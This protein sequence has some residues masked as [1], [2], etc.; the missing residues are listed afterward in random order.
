MTKKIT[1]IVSTH[2]RPAYLK[3]VLAGYLH[4]T[5]LPGELVVADD[6]SGQPTRDVV[7]R[8]RAQAPFPVIHAWQPHART[9]RLSHLR[10]L[11]TR[12]SSGDYLVY[13]DGDCV[14]TRHFV[15]DH[16][17]LA[18]PGWFV[19]AKRMWVRYK[20]LLPFT[21]QE[22][23]SQL[24]KLAAQGGLGKPQWLVHIPGIG[25]PK[26]TIK[27]IRG[28][29]MAVFRSDVERINGHNEE[30]LGFWRQDSEFALRLMR[31]GV[32]RKDA[33]F[34]AMVFHLEHEK[35]FVAEDFERNS[36]LFSTQ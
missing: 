16:L 21:G 6:G 14:P 22:S 32:R 29:N 12:S 23:N 35:E 11:A 2:N 30:F 9:V 27:G 18:R 25:V 20:A 8:F 24:L 17:R 19:Q 36:R 1:V 5:V 13:T 31:S 34:S 26:K 10:N 28:C 3:K 4:Q 33:F 15:S 7:D